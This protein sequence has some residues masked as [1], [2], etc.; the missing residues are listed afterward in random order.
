VRVVGIHADGRSVADE[1][2]VVAAGGKLLAELG[3]DDAGAAVGWVAGD[4]D[5]HERGSPVSSVVSRGQIGQHSTG[6]ERPCGVE[7]VLTYVHEQALD[8]AR[9]ALH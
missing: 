2:D 6:K 4:A 1:V 3:G 8:L 5:F 7:R 9:K